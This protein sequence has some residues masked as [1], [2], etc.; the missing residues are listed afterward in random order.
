M[1]KIFLNGHACTNV[2]KSQ[3]VQKNFWECGKYT[4]F[5]LMVIIVT[6]IYTSVTF[7]L[8][9]IFKR[10]AFTACKSILFLDLN[11]NKQINK[12]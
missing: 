1:I 2:L 11:K 8:N 10:C 4:F 7:L 3:E 9:C 6:W 12:K 5:V